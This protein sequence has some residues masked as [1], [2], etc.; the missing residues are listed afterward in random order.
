[1]IRYLLAVLV[2]ITLPLASQAQE[3]IRFSNNHGWLPGDKSSV[4]HTQNGKLA[5]QMVVKKSSNTG[6]HYYVVGFTSK[7]GKREEFG[8]RITHVEPTRTHFRMRAEPGKA[9]SWGEHLPTGLKT[10]YV[11]IG[12]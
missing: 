8:A 11:Y 7:T 10:V 4:Y 12:P 1:M 2:L 5:M 6:R 3:V 9:S